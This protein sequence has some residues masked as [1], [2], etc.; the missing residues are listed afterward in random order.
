MNVKEGNEGNLREKTGA[1]MV[2]MRKVVK[3]L[4]DTVETA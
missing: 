4:A 1:T 2:G 3:I